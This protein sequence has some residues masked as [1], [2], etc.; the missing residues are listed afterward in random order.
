MP[1]LSPAVQ[2]ALLMLLANACGAGMNAVIR[3][4]AAELHPFEIAFF[5]NLFGLLA[6]LPFLGGL[7]IG[8]LR[9]RHLGRLLMTGGAQVFSMLSMFSAIA[10]MPLAEV[11][12][13]SFTKPL[14][15]TI[16]AALVLHEVVRARRWSAVA[17]GFVGV[18]IVV[19]PG[20]ETMTPAAGLA[21]ASTLVFAG[22]TLA[23]KRLV[24][25][26]RATVVVLYQ[27]LVTA[28]LSLPPA[29]LFWRLPSLGAW[30]W[31]ALTGVLGTVG[32]LCFTRAFQLADASALMPYEFLKLPMV[33]LL[34]YW[35]FAEV[36]S[37]WTWLGGAVIFTSTVYIAHREA[38]VAR[39]ARAARVTGGGVMAPPVRPGAGG[40]S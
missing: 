39:T 12:A 33:A 38:K 6:M 8:M 23:I 37:V 2:A 40:A 21:L 11:T 7:G 31:L 17:I 34:A 26:E 1:T 14:F 13:L 27:A 36:P 10:L 5:R 25:L 15:A 22:I 19:R 20:A 28:A 35:V 32:W 30:P 29:L 9:T 3:H 16:G 4:L 18:M 24:M